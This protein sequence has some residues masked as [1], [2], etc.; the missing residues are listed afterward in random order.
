MTQEVGVEGDYSA[1]FSVEPYEPLR[2]AKLGR[3]LGTTRT[4]RRIR[5]WNSPLWDAYCTLFTEPRE[6]FGLSICRSGPI[7]NTALATKPLLV[8]NPARPSFC[9][10]PDEVN[11]A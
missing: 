1:G 5:E 4:R 9:T 10:L 3:L 2:L 8:N 7:T 11:F 6:V